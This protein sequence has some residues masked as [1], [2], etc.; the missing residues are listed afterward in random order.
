VAV[1][2]SAA[3]LDAID[4]AAASARDAVSGLRWVPR[5]QWHVTLQ[6]LGR[7]PDVDALVRALDGVRSRAVV[8]ARLGGAGAFGKAR[9]GTVLWLGVREGA[10]ELAALAGAVC[11]ETARVGFAPEDRPFQPHLTLARAS[12]PTDLRDAVAAL[13]MVGDVG[14][15]WTVDHVVVVESDTR[16]EGAVHREIARV[17]LAAGSAE[18]R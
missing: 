17:A 10:D 14:P 12:T 9:R 16:P 5:D 2:P 15:A 6:F 11:D 7:V 18:L 3:V 1:R 8:C 4:A 13:E